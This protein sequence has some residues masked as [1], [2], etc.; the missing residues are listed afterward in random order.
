MNVGFLGTGRVARQL[1]Y[2]AQTAGHDVVL[3]SRRGG[4]EAGGD[5]TILSLSDAVDF[6]DLIVLAVPYAACA[7]LLPPLIDGLR[8]KV[9][10]DA[11]N[12]LNVDWSPLVLANGRSGAEELASLLPASSVV[13][14]FNTV[15]ADTMTSRGLERGGAKIT[16][17]I[18]GDDAEA[19]DTVARFAESLGFHARLAGPLRNAAHLE[20]LAHLNIHIA[21]HEGAGTDVAVVYSETSS[22]GARPTVASPSMAAWE[23][24]WARKDAAAVAACYSA[25]GVLMHPKQQAVVSREAIERFVSGGV[26]KLH[27]TFEPTALVGTESPRFEYGS[28]ADRDPVSGHEVARGTY[29]VTWVLDGTRWLIR[30][31]GWNSPAS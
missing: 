9:V 3:G 8:G 7:G 29:A 20:A 2:L 12:P 14:A 16:T 5:P 22:R 31:H 13:K 11:T 21:V 10:I 18:A 27:V 6:A 23:A 19:R 1:A 4:Q 17:F 24:A 30:F 26:G 28:F 15:F 25:D